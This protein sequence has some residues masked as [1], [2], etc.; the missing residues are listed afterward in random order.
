MSLHI[1]LNQD[2]L[3]KICSRNAVNETVWKY[4]H[5]LQSALGPYWQG[6]WVHDQPDSMGQLHKTHSDG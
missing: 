3:T 2:L 4:G 1:I 6:L 5:E